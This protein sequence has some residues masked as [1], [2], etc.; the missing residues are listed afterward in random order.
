MERLAT[1]TLAAAVRNEKTAV[2][3]LR[4]YQTSKMDLFGENSYLLKVIT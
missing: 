1:R 3:Y 4:P 2:V